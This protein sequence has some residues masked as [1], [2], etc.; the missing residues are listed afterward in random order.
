M[1]AARARGLAD[2]TRVLGS[3]GTDR[4]RKET[5]TND[6]LFG[7]ERDFKAHQAAPKD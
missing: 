3:A 2:E 4:A 7:A 5:V 6:R 1:A